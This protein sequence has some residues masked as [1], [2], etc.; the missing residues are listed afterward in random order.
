MLPVNEKLRNQLNWYINGKPLKDD[1][2][3]CMSFM[4]RNSQNDS[5]L[6]GFEFAQLEIEFPREIFILIFNISYE[7]CCKE[8]AEDSYYEFGVFKEWDRVRE[9]NYPSFEDL[10][11]NYQ[12]LAEL[13]IKSDDV[14][15]SELIYMEPKSNPKNGYSLKRLEAVS[16]MKDKVILKG[17]VAFDARIVSP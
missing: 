9:L 10:L 15:I 5:L 3:V 1:Q 6:E 2:W 17:I 14:D 12:D 13:I 11:Q 7:K 16:I 4:G 8:D